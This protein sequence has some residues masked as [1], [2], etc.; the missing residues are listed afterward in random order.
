MSDSLIH[1]RSITTARYKK[2]GKYCRHG[3]NI[4]WGHFLHIHILR[5]NFSIGIAGH[6]KQLFDEWMALDDWR[7]R[8]EEDST[9]V[10]LGIVKSRLFQEIHLRSKANTSVH[11]IVDTKSGCII[12]II[13]SL[14]LV[15]LM[16]S[17]TKDFRVE[18]EKMWMCKKWPCKI[19]SPW[20]QYFPIFFYILQLYCVH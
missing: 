18:V 8:W 13:H 3:K 19:F 20:W 16:N 5:A 14:P 15:N 7:K 11:L 12:I 10:G 2:M 9:Y 1:G 17:Q 6:T 4:F